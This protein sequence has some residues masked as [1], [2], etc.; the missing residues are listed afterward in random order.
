MYDGRRRLVLLLLVL[1]LL[2]R[3]QQVEEHQKLLGRL[4]HL[5]ET[6]HEVVVVHERWIHLVM[7]F[8]P[9]YSV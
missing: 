7:F 8:S 2:L 6:Y 9:P 5:F 1:Y 4:I 3:S